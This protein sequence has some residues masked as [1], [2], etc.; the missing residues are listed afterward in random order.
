MGFSSI[1]RGPCIIQDRI[2]VIPPDTLP[3]AASLPANILT[4]L[5]AEAGTASPSPQ[6]HCGPIAPAGT[7]LSNGAAQP[8]A[9]PC[10]PRPGC[11][12]LNNTRLDTDS[13]QGVFEAISRKTTLSKRC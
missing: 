9:S 13:A 7:T 8:A 6:P 11:F 12:D 2:V 3:A 5:A 1:L 10:L 4:D